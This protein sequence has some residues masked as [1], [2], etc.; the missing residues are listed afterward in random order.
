MPTDTHKMYKIT[1]YECMSSFLH[2]SVGVCYIQG[3]DNMKEF[4]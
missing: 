2:V 3:D 1:S 4:I